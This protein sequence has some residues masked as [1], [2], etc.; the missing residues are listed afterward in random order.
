M[1][2]IKFI[3]NNYDKIEIQCN[4][5][6]EYRANITEIIVKSKNL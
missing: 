6:E 4:C 3:L 1:R 5:K 2:T